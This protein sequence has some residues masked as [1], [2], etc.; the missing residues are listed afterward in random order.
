[1]L[2]AGLLIFIGL[3]AA[4]GFVLWRWLIRPRLHSRSA[5]VLVTLLAGVVWFVGPIADELLGAR[6][7]KRLCDEM[8]PVEF[9]GPVPIGPGAFF[10]E[11]GRPRW[12]TSDEFWAIRRKTK[13]WERIF[14]SREET[15]TL[16][17]W[18]FIVL[19][20]KTIHYAKATGQPI[21]ISRFRGSAGGWL[22]RMTGWGAYSPYQ[23]PF[24]ERYPPDND[25]ITFKPTDQK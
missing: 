15:T 3:W 16:S 22:K 23:C 24:K 11:S 13:D 12:R 21:L 7:F 17:T 1:M 19:E 20:M 9:Y 10:D 6:Q 14:G 2:G 5:L 18:P 8:P 4:V 25:W